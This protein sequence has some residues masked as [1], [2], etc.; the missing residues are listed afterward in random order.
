MSQRVKEKFILGAGE[1]KW[2]GGGGDEKKGCDAARRFEEVR[3][4]K[5]R[6]PGNGSEV[7]GVVMARCASKWQKTGGYNDKKSTACY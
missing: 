1:R 4:R 2:I 3:G 5:S 6:K 7:T